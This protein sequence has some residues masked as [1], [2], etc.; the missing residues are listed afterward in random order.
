MKNLRAVCSSITGEVRKNNEDNYCFFSRFRP[1]EQED[2]GFLVYSS[3][4]GEIRQLEYPET[5][6]ESALQ[7]GIETEGQWLG[8]FDGIG[9]LPDGEIASLIAASSLAE[10]KDDW[11]S[12]NEAE[13][14]EQLR[15]TVCQLNSD[16]FSWR[17]SHKVNQIGTTMAAMKFGRYAIYGVNSGDSRIY[18]MRDGRLTQLTKDHVFYYPGHLRPMLI[19]FLGTEQEDEPVRA[20]IYQW[21]YCPGDKY[22]LCTDGVSGMIWDKELE[23]IMCLPVDEA[24]EALM[25]AVHRMG[26]ADNATAIILEIKECKE[27]FGDG[28][29]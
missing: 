21:D 10:A 26:A 23:E 20:D 27:Y 25:A 28:A 6:E 11:T 13:Y 24:M 22:L 3:E 4:S 7:S 15:K 1:L 2:T 18:R 5:A 17:K 19:G 29:A 12:E 14:E 8:V 16:M 9:G